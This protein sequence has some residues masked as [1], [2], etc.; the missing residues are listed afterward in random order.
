MKGADTTA[1][2]GRK[3]A[4]GHGRPTL[5]RV[6][7]SGCELGAP[8]R[9][10]LAYARTRP[11]SARPDTRCCSLSDGVAGRIWTDVC[12]RVPLRRG[13]AAPV[14]A[15]GSPRLARDRAACRRVLGDDIGSSG[16]VPH[17]LLTAWRPARS[18]GQA[19]RA[20][21]SSWSR[22]SPAGI[23]RSSATTTACPL[24]SWF[25]ACATA[26]SAS[27]VR[28]RSRWI[29]RRPVTR[30]RS[31]V[32][33]SDDHDAVDVRRMSLGAAG[34]DR[35]RSRRCRGGAEPRRR[36]RFR[37]G[38]RARTVPRTRRRVAGECRRA[39][40]RSTGGGRVRARPWR[41]APRLRGAPRPRWGRLCIAW[42]WRSSPF[43]EPSR[44]VL[45]ALVMRWSPRLGV[46]IGVDRARWRSRAGTPRRL[47][48]EA[49]PPLVGT[50]PLG[51]WERGA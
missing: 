15:S 46:V 49:A 10:T 39:V 44:F 19:A 33:V 37:P 1:L 4:S 48:G 24:C 20:S 35:R 14:I 45:G 6:V 17:L 27:A 3:Q 5:V 7:R 16:R 51:S 34:R 12:E 11:W 50:R 8:T 32:V 25:T 31:A 18:G 26:S 21:C 23:S 2:P 22:A 36:H 9:V 41:E 40:R 13:S 30:V 38:H 28:R 43:V 29:P 42:S 47:A